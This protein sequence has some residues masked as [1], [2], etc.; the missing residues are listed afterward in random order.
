MSKTAQ[1]E[2]IVI[3]AVGRRKTAIARLYLT[4]G[5]GKISMNHRTIESYFP[6]EILRSTVLQPLT[7]LGKR[8]A[9]DLRVN[10]RGGGSKSQAESVRMALARAL[11][12]ADAENRTVLKDHQLLTRD[13]R[14]VERKKYGQ[15]KARRKFQFSKR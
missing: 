12:E 15:R 8:K 10:V 3:H 11:C 9:Y 14:M 4:Q 6:H 2:A 13:P 5:K 7:L 1:E